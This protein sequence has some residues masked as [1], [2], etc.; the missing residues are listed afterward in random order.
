MLKTLTYNNSSLSNMDSII[1]KH[2][3][4]TLHNMIIEKVC[5]IAIYEIFKFPVMLL[6]N[7]IK[8]QEFQ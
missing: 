1:I 8:D 7:E 4:S 6:N 2:M 5:T 3:D